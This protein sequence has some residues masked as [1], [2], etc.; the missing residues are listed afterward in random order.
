MPGSAPPDRAL[1]QRPSF[2]D[3]RL[4][5]TAFETGRSNVP[6]A[7][8]MQNRVRG[9]PPRVTDIAVSDLTVRDA[10]GPFSFRGYQRDLI[11]SIRLR[12]GRFDNLDAAP[13]AQRQFVSRSCTTCRSAPINQLYKP[14]NH[15]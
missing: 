15:C 4:A 5:V 14:P 1:Y 9:C 11:G 12:D 8:A 13:G 2:P 7:C 6:T 3:R 10:A